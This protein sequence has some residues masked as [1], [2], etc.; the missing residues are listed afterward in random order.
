MQDT[1][2]VNGIVLSSMPVG[3]ADRRVVL[4]TKELGRISCFAHGARKPTSR[5]V[6]ATRT[7]AFGR[8]ELFQGRDAYSSR[9]LK[10]RKARHTE[11]TSQNSPRISHGRIRMKERPRASCITA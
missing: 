4:L 7:F 9:C 11:A 8:F 5:M 6:G 1:I 2:E 10:T 3:E